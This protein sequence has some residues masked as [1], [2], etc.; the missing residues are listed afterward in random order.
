MIWNFGKSVSAAIALI[1]CT[2]EQTVERCRV[3]DTGQAANGQ[4]ADVLILNGAHAR[5]SECRIDRSSDSGVA[6]VNSAIY[7]F[8][9]LDASDP[10]GC[11]ADVSGNYLN[12]MAPAA[13]V[14][15][16]NLDGSA[17]SPVAFSPIGASGYSGAQG[18]AIAPLLDGH[19]PRTVH[20]RNLN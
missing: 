4:C 19:H 9:T 5:V 13:A 7:V 17:I 2:G 1:E 16:I 10:R 15:Q 18:R 11:S 3:L 8:P 12:L 6:A 14:G 20:F